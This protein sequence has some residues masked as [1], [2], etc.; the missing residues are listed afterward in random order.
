MRERATALRVQRQY[1]ST[2]RQPVHITVDRPDVSVGRQQV[3]VVYQVRAIAV[4][5]SRTCAQ[6]VANEYA[7]HLQYRYNQKLLVYVIMESKLAMPPT[8]VNSAWPSLR[9]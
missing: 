9:G 1:I 8:Q 4:R 6:N 3:R 7:R 2:G 5:H